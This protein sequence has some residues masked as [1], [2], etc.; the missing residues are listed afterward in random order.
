[1]TNEALPDPILGTRF[2]EA[3]R[4]AVDLH[5]RQ[6]RKG[7]KIPYLGH[8]LGVCGLVIDGGGT[9]D[10]AIAAVLHDAVED[11]GGAA[12]L[13]LIRTQFGSDVAAIVAACSDTDVLPKPAWRPRKEA[14][15]EHLRAAADP[16]VLRVSLADKVNNLRAIVR[17]Y[18]E[19]GE[20]LWARFNPDADQIWYYGS[21]LEVFERQFPVPMTTELRETY[22]RLLELTHPTSVADG[23]G[24]TTDRGTLGNSPAPEQVDDGPSKRPAVRLLGDDP[25]VVTSTAPLGPIP[26]SD[27]WAATL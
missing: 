12:T 23:T 7:S 16:P 20:E 11:Q 19:I 8:L 15:I 2:V 27:T 5:S 10:E 14:Y 4:L 13:E 24:D 18:G 6:I 9:E 3:L 21:L 25:E 26:P 1:M 17:D 22:A